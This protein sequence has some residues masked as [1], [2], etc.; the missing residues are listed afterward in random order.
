MVRAS[1]EQPATHHSTPTLV[2]SNL[3][4][5]TSNRSVTCCYI[6]CAD[7]CPGKVWTVKTKPQNTRWSRKKRWKLPS[8][9]SA[10]TSRTSSKTSSSTAA[11]SSSRRSPTTRSAST[12]SA[13][14]SN[15][16]KS[17]PNPTSTFGRK[18]SLKFRSRS[19]LRAL[20]GSL[21]NRRW[22]RRKRTANRSWRI[23]SRR[24]LAWRRTRMRRSHRLRRWIGKRRNRI[25]WSRLIMRCWLLPQNGRKWEGL[26]KLRELVLCKLGV[27]HIKILV[28][29]KLWVMLQ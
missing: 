2:W 14:A 13:S 20:R 17:T 6:S 22:W 1:P 26:W 19:W 7:R 29:F 12:C 28:K 5:T 10:R 18:T 15:A 4:A 21:G 27:N 24:W 23:S 3:G 9:L 25:W 11:S 16:T 8:I